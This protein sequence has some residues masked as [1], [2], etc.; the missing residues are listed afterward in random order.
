[1]A[2]PGPADR[3]EGGRKGRG[4]H[5][6]CASPRGA[7]GDRRQAPRPRRHVLRA[8]RARRRHARDEESPG[9]RPSAR[10][11]RC[12]ASRPR[13]G[14]QAGQRHRVRPR[15]VFLQPRHRPHL[16]RRGRRWSTGIVGI[17]VGI[18]STEVAPFGGMKSSGLGREGSKYGIEEYLE[19]KYLCMGGVRCSSRAPAM[20]SCGTSKAAA[21]SI[22]SAGIAVVNTGHCH[23]RVIAAAQGARWPVHPHLL[24]GGGLRRLRQLCERL[25]ALA[26]GDA[27]KKTM[28]INT[29]AEAV[30][31]SIKIARAWT[32]RPGVIAFHGGFHG[33]TLLALGLTGKVDPYKKASG[34]SPARSSMRPSPA[35]C[36]ASA[37]TTR[38]TASS[39]CS[40]TTSSPAASRPS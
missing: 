22:S 35:R 32:G 31:N 36:T 40:R 25:N 37:P 24:P 4:A 13:R 33:R 16:A 39:C 5:R 9:R 1:M 2:C 28:L 12:S 26:P 8:D 18:I 34:R 21:T 20:P 15:L 10:W 30:E 27:P 14:D 17:N 23:P 6:R 29:G 7:R 11:R 19:I 3:H 38:S